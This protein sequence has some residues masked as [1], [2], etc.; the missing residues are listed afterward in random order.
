M[1]GIEDDTGVCSKG[2]VSAMAGIEDDT[3]GRVSVGSEGVVACA[4]DV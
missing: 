3:G 4:E 1:A 2:V